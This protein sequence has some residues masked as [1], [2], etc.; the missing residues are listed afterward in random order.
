LGLIDPKIATIMT[1][2]IGHVM[3]LYLLRHAQAVEPN[4]K[5]F[6]I[7]SDRTL[8]PEGKTRAYR[9]ARAMKELDLTFS[10]IVSS[11]YLRARQTAE[12]VA[13]VLHAE[14]RMLLSNH[15]APTGK[16]VDLI[17]EFRRRYSYLDQVLLVGHEPCLSMLIAK[18][19]TGKSTLAVS[20]KKAALVKLS[21]DALRYSRCARLE[22]LI[23]PKFLVA[24]GC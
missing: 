8:T 21:T 17:A 3:E 23:P 13:K 12:I 15:L 6:E 10:I 9:V 7:D 20:V 5:G 4:S 1:G 19:V 18:L 2:G 22:W 11:P 24:L 14:D 16:A